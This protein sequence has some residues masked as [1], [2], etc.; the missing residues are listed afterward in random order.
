MAENSKIKV[1]I[2]SVDQYITTIKEMKE[3]TL[4]RNEFNEPCNICKMNKEQTKCIVLEGKCGHRFHK[5]C[6]DQWTSKYST[7][8][9]PCC[10]TKWEPI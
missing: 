4:C 2:M 10:D 3:C 1:E 8:P 7:C 6:V 9:Y 5:H